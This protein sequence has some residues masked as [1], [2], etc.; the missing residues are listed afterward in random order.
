MTDALNTTAGDYLELDDEQLVK[1]CLVDCYRASGPGG[2]KRNKTSSA[3]R[4][5][6]QP[7]GIAVIAVEDR[8]Q[9]VNK[10]RAVRR[11]RMALALNLRT[12][13]DSKEYH[14]SDL[15]R[16]C[17]SSG[18][19]LSLGRRDKRYPFIVSELLDLLQACDTG[20]RDAASL[21]GITTSNL[22]KFFRKDEKLWR[23]VNNLR[24]RCGRKTLR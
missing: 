16:S 14:P 15:M 23:C 10:A 21:I 19:T 6:H 5:R 7:T 2:Q 17:V 3:V 8:S 20:V 24:T 13:F 22:V 1:Q 18:G 9:H 4:L 12:A 11:L